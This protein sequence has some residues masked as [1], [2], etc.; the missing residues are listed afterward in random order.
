MFLHS[1]RR[2]YIYLL[3]PLIWGILSYVLFSVLRPM[4]PINHLASAPIWI[5][6]W[7][8]QMAI[9]APFWVWI[10]KQNFENEQRNTIKVLKLQIPLGK[11]LY[12]LILAYLAAIAAIP[13]HNT[14]YAEWLV[15]GGIVSPIFEELFSRN[16]LT[17][18]LKKSWASFLF[19]SA[20]SSTAFTLM[21]W[22]FNNAEAFS[23]TP[24]QQ[25]L[26]F[27]SH[28]VFAIALCIIFRF[29]KSIQL[30]IWLHIASNL[31][32]IITKF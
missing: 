20:I 19:V 22:G 9:F 1:G 29:T 27:L 10:L 4:L 32:F 2:H 6:L 16:L 14:W 18:W 26:K 8:L 21:H 24:Q 11:P 31:Q 7:V 17:P 28:F 3:A 25:M 23:F 5:W 13:F 30:L 12:Y 15:F